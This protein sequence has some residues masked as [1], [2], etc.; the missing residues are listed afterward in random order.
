MGDAI[1]FGLHQIA[2]EQ[3]PMRRHSYATY[4]IDSS[5]VNQSLQAWQDL[6]DKA[7]RMFR[8]TRMKNIVLAQSN[9]FWQ[10]VRRLVPWRNLERVQISKQ[11]ATHRFSTH[12]PHTHRGSALLFNDG[13]REVTVEDLTDIRYPRGRFQKQVN[14][15]TFF[16]GMAD[17]PQRELDQQL[18]PSSVQPPD[19][20]NPMARAD[21]LGSDITFPE[22]KDYN[23]ETKGI[24]TRLHKNL[25]HPPDTE[26]KKLLAMNGVSNQ[27][28]LAAVD[29]LICG[30]CR[31]TR[32]P[33]PAT[34]SM[35]QSNFRQFADAIQVDIVYIRDITG[36]NFSVLGIID[37]CTHLHQACILESRLPEEVLRKFIQT[38]SQPFG[39]PLG[40]R[41]DAD[42]S[43]RAAFEEHL[44][45]TGT[46]AEFVPPEAHHRMGLIERHNAT[47]RT[48][49][50][51]VMRVIDAQGVVGFR[52]ME[53]A[54]RGYISQRTHYMVFR[55]ASLH[56]RLRTNSSYLL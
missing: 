2:A 24:V 27:K 44:D 32:A 56:S 29:D 21:M 14:I 40:C 4:A 54:I 55:T 9:N 19:E 1:L 36:Q 7:E 45:A 28:I 20:D 50:E 51:R 25:G 39:F 42:G 18:Q 49:A 17:P 41:L 22:N 37:E 5:E 23:K 12:L 3:D 53:M 47:L 38:W 43:F 15:G 31:S 35:P 26:L 48:I 46:F 10:D 33:K 16:F 11:P 52:Q 8:Q 30:S 13:S 6:F 34:A